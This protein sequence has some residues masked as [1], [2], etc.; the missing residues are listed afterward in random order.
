M[1]PCWA[2]QFNFILRRAPAILGS[3]EEK[4]QLSHT[5]HWNNSRA[6][7]SIYLPGKCMDYSDNDRKTSSSIIHK[8]L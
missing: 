2:A 6:F 5:N 8:P 7:I 4:M 3:T 1:T